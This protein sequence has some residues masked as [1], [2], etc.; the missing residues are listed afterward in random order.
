MT[1]ARRIQAACA[2]RHGAARRSAQWTLL[3]V[4][5]VLA[6]SGCGHKTSQGDVLA[7]VNGRDVSRADVALTRATAHI[8]G[9]ELTDSQA[10]EKAIRME[11]VRREAD[12]LQVA[13]T[14]AAVAARIAAVAKQ[15]GGIDK[16]NAELTKENLSTDQFRRAVA[17]ALLSEQLGASK[18]SGLAVPQAAVHAFYEKNI[19]LFTVPAAVKIGSIECKLEPIAAR[20]AAELQHG[21]SF[22]KMARLHS[23]ELESGKHGGMLG[24]VD[25]SSL[26]T[27]LADAIAKLHEGEVSPPIASFGGWFL[28]K[29]YDRR[30]AKT[31]PFAQVAAEL[32]RELVRRRQAGALQ[33]WVERVRAHADVVIIGQGGK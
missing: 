18:F 31:S 19:A 2:R 22:A 25:V 28:I 15:V 3:A 33:R 1:F 13:V 4:V 27:P 6:V 12:R 20:I 24:W 17:D 8:A 26:P 7:R 11:I 30:T 9:V 10:L 29:F 5:A 14:D 16:L 21:A 32:R 23:Q